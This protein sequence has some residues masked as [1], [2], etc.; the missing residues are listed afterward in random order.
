MLFT[1]LGRLKLFAVHNGCLFP[2]ILSNKIF[3]VVTIKL[4]I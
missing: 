3:S 2:H 4:I 1:I